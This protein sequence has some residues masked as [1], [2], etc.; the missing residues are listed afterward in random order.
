MAKVVLNKTLILI[1]F[2]KKDFKF[3]TIE[4]KSVGYNDVQVHTVSGKLGNRGRESIKRF[5]GHDNVLKEAMKF[6]YKRIYDLKE[7][8]G[9]LSERKLK[10]AII[11]LQKKEKTKRKN[12]KENKYIC[13]LCNSPIK[14]EIYRKI[15][16]WARGDG[17]WDKDPKFV[18][19]K[20]VLC[21]DCQIEHDIFKKRI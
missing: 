19:Y 4:V 6:A 8:E 17:N 16:D 21:L 1:D 7:S 14:P 9:Y 2:D 11:D 10:N 13:N 3:E 5:K 20:K 12:V 15:N 18:G